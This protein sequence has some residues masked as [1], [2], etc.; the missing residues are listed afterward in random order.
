MEKLRSDEVLVA[1]MAKIN[2]LTFGSARAWLRESFGKQHMSPL[3]R[4]YRSLCPHFRGITAATI[5]IPAELPQQSSHY[6]GKHHGNRG[7]TAIPI[8]VS[9]FSGH[10]S[11]F[12]TNIWLLN[13]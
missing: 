1:G 11:R 4:V 6:R 10:E 5:P 7:I 3:P 2:K 8:P 13:R 12:S 9:I